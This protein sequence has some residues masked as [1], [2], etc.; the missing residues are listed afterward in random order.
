MFEIGKQEIT[1]DFAPVP[2]GLYNAFVDKAEFKT[3]KAGAEYLN[4]SFKLFGEHYANRVVFNIYNV[5]HTKEQVK[6]IE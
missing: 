6:N 4:A 5:F 1:D 3:S 2:K